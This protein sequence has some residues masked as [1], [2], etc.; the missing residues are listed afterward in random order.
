MKSTMEK[1]KMENDINL[2]CVRAESFPDGIV[3]AHEKLKGISKNKNQNH[4]GV[5]YMDDDAILY[6]A[7][8]ENKGDAPIPVGCKAFTLKKGTYISF[9]IRNFAENISAIQD[10]FKILTDHPRIDPEGCCVEAYLPEGTNMFTA[11]DVRCM[12]RLADHT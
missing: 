6:M 7:G 1:F 4:F 3:A 2:F 12:V 8:E 9:Y 11:K 10:A 5:S